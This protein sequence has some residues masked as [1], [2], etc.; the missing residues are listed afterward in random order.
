VKAPRRSLLGVTPGGATFSVDL[1]GSSKYSSVIL[2]LKAEVEKGSMSTAIEHGL[3]D[4]KSWG[5]PVIR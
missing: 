2:R 1:G 3:I 4:P 5:K